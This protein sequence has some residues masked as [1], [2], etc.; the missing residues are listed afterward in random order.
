MPIY[1][2]S[3]PVNRR[4]YGYHWAVACL[5]LLVSQ[6][7]MALSMPPILQ[8]AKNHTYWFEQG[9]PQAS[10]QLYIIAEP[11]CAACHALYQSLL[12][13][14]A[15]GQLKV[16]WILVAFLKRSSAGKVASI[17]TSVNPAR[18]W[19]HNEATFDNVVEQGGATTKRLSTK[20]REMIQTNKAFMHQY[21]FHSTPVL[22][23]QQRDKRAGQIR[24]ALS[25]DQIQ[26]LLA[27]IYR[28]N[29]A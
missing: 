15:S 2:Y 16:R 19:H 28:A 25:P 3:Q 10:R 8:A 23:F 17:L 20:T 27:G 29:H 22:L 4:R 24:G 6:W 7:T 9:N 12:T 1:N 11:N 13:S 14:I 26:Q 21:G 5:L 18:A